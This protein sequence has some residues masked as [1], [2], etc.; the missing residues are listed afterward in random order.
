LQS[1]RDMW[2]LDPPLVGAV[3][4]EA[5]RLNAMRVAIDN[6]LHTQFAGPMQAH[7]I[8]VDLLCLESISRAR[9]CSLA[10]CYMSSRSIS[11]RQRLCLGVL[12]DQMTLLSWLHRDHWARGMA[13]KV[14]CRPS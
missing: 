11:S 5:K 10:A 12:A 8:E 2:L 13:T 1:V 6:D 14:G 7:I 4:R 3:P 9:S